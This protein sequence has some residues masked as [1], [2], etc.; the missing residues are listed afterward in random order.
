V[1]KAGRN[2][3]ENQVK[4]L[5]IDFQKVEREHIFQV[6]GQIVFH[7]FSSSELPEESDQ[8]RF[9][10]DSRRLLYTDRPDFIVFMTL[11][12]KVCGFY[13]QVD[14]KKFSVVQCNKI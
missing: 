5:K 11:T 4:L 8:F 9:L 6:F 14:T 7:Q 2:T 10:R 1:R 13:H 12:V 3:L